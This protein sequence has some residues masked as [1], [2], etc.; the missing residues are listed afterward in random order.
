[1]PDALESGTLNVAGI[2]GLAA[3]VR[4]VSEIGI[5]KIRGHEQAL[6]EQFLAGASLIPNMT[7]YGPRDARLRCGVVSF[8]ITG[9]APSEVSLVLDDTFEIMSRS[10]LHCAPAA[11]RTLG[12]FPTGTVRFGFNW[13]NTS[14]D[15]HGALEALREIAEWAAEHA[16]PRLVKSWTA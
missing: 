5:E 6:V 9:I 11:H 7:M 13:F 8:N 1:V 12:T 2:A 14:A 10:G 15:V 3:G 16:D 4:F